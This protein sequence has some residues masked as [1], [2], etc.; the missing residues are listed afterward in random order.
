VGVALDTEYGK[1]RLR[2]EELRREIEEHDY[3]YYVFDDPVISDQE[4][5]RLIKEL[6]QYEKLYPELITPF[7][8]TQ[9]VGG[10][11]GQGFATVAHMAPMLSL[12]N[13]FSKEE[14]KD[15]DRRVRAALPGEKVEYVVEPKIDGL[16]VSL[17][18]ADGNLVLGATRGDGEIG[19][20]I[21]NNLKTIK[22]IPLHLRR[23]ASRLEVRGEAYMAKETFARLNNVRSEA[24]EQ[25]L[26]NPRNAAAGS[27]RQLDPRIA[28]Q[29]SLNI[30]VYAIGFSEGI[31]VQSHA[32]ALK[33][34][35]EAGFRVNPL[36]DIFDEIT[37]VVAY[38]REWQGKRFALPY[39]IDGLVIKVNS[40]KQQE[41]LGTTMKSPRW[42]IAYKFPPE[43][44][45]TKV[46]KIDVNVG[47]TGVLTPTAE[48]DT[49]LLSGT[50]VTRAT[51]HNE[52][53]IR[54]KD[55]RIGD[56]VI[57]Q[58]AGDVIPE[59]VEVVKEKRT[60]QEKIWRMPGECPICHSQTVRL[61][62]E[63]AVR[64]T[65]MAC[66]AQNRESLIHFV[67]RNAMDIIG[68]GPAVIDQ[69]LEAKLI[70][71]PSDLYELQYED[72]ISLE[73]LG[74]KSASN[75]LDAI[76]KSK[77]NSLARLVFA[78][79][80]RHVGEKAARILAD[81]FGTL[82][83]LMAA[84]EGEM[85]VISEIGPKI[86]ESI[87]DFFSVEQ[88]RLVIDKLVKAGV[89]TFEKRKDQTGNKLMAGLTFVITGTLGGYTRQEAQE[90][91]REQGGKTSSS[92]SRSTDFLVCGENPGSKYEKAIA[93]GVKI[94]NE[95]QFKAMLDAQERID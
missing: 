85:T 13:A 49:V 26:A 21:T 60:G 36:I 90:I 42:A 23:Y 12:A 17:R 5:D 19:E 11:P 91:I 70:N 55:I 94:L 79:G 16:A 71:D 30:F 35:K 37:D 73:R 32:Q 27:L 50:R 44:A 59:V 3:R 80:I 15:F 89:N 24:G 72:L 95:E 10:Q 48:F 7:S 82:D 20:D 29:R 52:D 28:A 54:L 34:L 65:S 86:A 62:G 66:P 18:Y 84:K 14:L 9:R 64:C 25:L 31:T 67:S 75:L 61:E 58:K 88:N 77:E 46:K 47:R 68:L 51:L 78:L 22:S 93:L 69:L 92:V 45:I 33:F 43:Q 74:P 40:L 41:R 2:V 1:A 53:M 8:P 39:V 63:A 83:N 56:T 76:Y 38:C 81:H 4:Y 6:E 87:R 57:V